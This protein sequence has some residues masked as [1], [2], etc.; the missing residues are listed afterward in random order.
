MFPFFT[1]RC[2]PIPAYGFKLACKRV[3]Q[4]FDLNAP[5]A[6]SKQ[7]IKLVANAVGSMNCDHKQKSVALV[8]LSDVAVKGALKG[9]QDDDDVLSGEMN[10]QGQ[11][12]D[13]RI[14]IWSEREG[15]NVYNALPSCHF[16]RLVVDKS[17]KADN[18]FLNRSKLGT[19]RRPDSV[20]K[21]PPF[22]ALLQAE[23]LS[24][25]ADVLNRERQTTS[26][27]R[28]AAQKG[29]DFFASVVYSLLDGLGLTTAD[30]V[31]IM[32]FCPGIGCN[33]IGAR[34]LQTQNPNWS[35][36][37][38]SVETDAKDHEFANARVR[39]ELAKEWLEG[40][41]VHPALKPELT[42]PPLP[43]SIINNIPGAEG[44]M[45]DLA[46]VPW[47]VCRV[48]GGKLRINDQHVVGFRATSRPQP[49]SIQ[50][51]RYRKGAKHATTILL[52][53]TTRF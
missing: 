43:H 4:A 3:S 34:R 32:D 26:V 46:S 22:S 18:V 28:L 49:R 36:H 27:E 20:A 8:H 37:Y 38:F 30:P 52:N 45:G 14:A 12:V 51:H 7:R 6:R 33:A 25:D 40:S 50:R 15:G 24:A 5:F 11:D 47:K 10:S 19:K 17:T 2:T 35:I 21:L 41:L 29:V 31:L 23:S 1:F 53:T 44:A 48:E 16:G 42:C 39:G 9:V 13:T